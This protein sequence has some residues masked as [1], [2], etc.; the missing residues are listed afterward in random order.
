MNDCTAGTKPKRLAY[1]PGLDGLRA[2][3]CLAVMM[4]HAEILHMTGGFLGVTVFFT[5]SGF[6]ITSLLLDE[7]RT[8]GRIDLRGFWRRRVHRIIPLFWFVSFSM[9]VWAVLTHTYVRGTITG[10]IGS[11]T[12]LVNFLNI[13][14]IGG[15]TNAG[16][17]GANWSVAIEEQFY[18]VWPVALLFLWRRF[19][20]ERILAGIVLGL[21]VA[22]AAHRFVIAPGV[23]WERW[24][25]GPDT[26][27]DAL[28]IGCAVALGVRSRSSLAPLAGAAGLIAMLFLAVEGQVISAQLC[29]PLTAI[30][31]ALVIPWLQD[32]RSVLSS[33]VMV[34]IGKR[35]YGL[36][37][38]GSP[39]GYLMKE[40]F[41]ATVP[42]AAVAAAL[43]F[44]VTEVTYRFVEIPMRARGRRHPRTTE[45]AAAA[46][47]PVAA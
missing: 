46:P 45:A 38:W 35:S 43:T 14:G 28:L 1:A 34:A 33:R 8:S 26:Q 22:L 44:A 32:H 16:T 12:F 25:F 20:S 18:L 17:L 10:A 31:T 15:A 41:G 5:L 9:A 13:G 6:L 37:L 42:A 23:P 7:L 27:A 30:S 19:R 11:L 3:A 29:M 47:L 21:A 39:I 2:V 24:W 40:T 36:Y 4:F